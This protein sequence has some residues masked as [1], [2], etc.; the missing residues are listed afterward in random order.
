MRRVR[1]DACQ[2]RAAGPL[3][4]TIVVGVSR[5]RRPSSPARP[6]N[7]SQP[8]S[9]PCFSIVVV[10]ATGAEAPSAPGVAADVVVV[11]T[12]FSP[13]AVI[14]GSVALVLA[15]VAEPD[16]PS[17]VFCACARLAEHKRAAA[18]MMARWNLI[19][20]IDKTPNTLATAAGHQK[21][22]SSFIEAV[23]QKYAL[24]LIPIKLATW[25]QLANS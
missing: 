3:P 2:D 1:W 21:H 15:A 22:K 8:R 4:E 12:L 14:A 24:G 10:V 16:V 9:K 18:H 20:R 23:P 13:D 5:L 25:N 6:S 17:A 7:P 19:C 11:A